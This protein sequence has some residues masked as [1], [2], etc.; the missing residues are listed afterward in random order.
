VLGD[1]SPSIVVYSSNFTEI[2]DTGDTLTPQWR[3]QTVGPAGT[4]WIQA[5]GATTVVS[6]SMQSAT[7][8]TILPNIKRRARSMGVFKR[9]NDYV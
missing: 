7:T 5:V 3:L 6:I 4:S 8:E 1:G 2:L 9:Y